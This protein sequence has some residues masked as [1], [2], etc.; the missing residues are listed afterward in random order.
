M[1]ILDIMQASP[2][3]PVIVVDDPAKAVPLARA[4]V[5]GGIRVLEVTLRTASA[6]KSIQQII[7]EVPEA[8]TGVGTITSVDQLKAVRDA[9][10]AFGVSPGLSDELLTQV[11]RV[12]FPFLP[13]VMTPSEVMRAHGL[14]F[15]ALKLFPAQQAGG[16]GMLKALGGP[17]PDTMF[18]PTGGVDAQTATDF[19]VLPNVGCVGGSWIAPKV[20]VDKLDWAGIT[21]LARS[22]SAL[23]APR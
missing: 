5:E 15:R 17:F 21:A 19:L 11:Q 10:A 2:V 13:G 4:L 16:I 22:A 6:M 7:R 23:R 12:G 14:G 3:M 1:K 20:L 8:I 9:G 18:C